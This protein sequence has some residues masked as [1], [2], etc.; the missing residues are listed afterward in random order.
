LREVHFEK[1]R[2]ALPAGL[3]EADRGELLDGRKVVEE[4]RAFLRERA[5]TAKKRS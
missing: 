1:L 4:M 2:A 5:G 3:E